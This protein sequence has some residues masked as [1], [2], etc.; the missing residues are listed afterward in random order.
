MTLLLG[1]VKFTSPE[2]GAKVGVAWYGGY[3]IL[4]GCLDYCFKLMFWNRILFMAL[5]FVCVSNSHEHTQLQICLAGISAPPTHNV[6]NWR[7]K[8]V[9][10]KAPKL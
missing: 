2:N 1:K 9:Y 5:R 4:F 3:G 6:F 10:P 8:G 7:K